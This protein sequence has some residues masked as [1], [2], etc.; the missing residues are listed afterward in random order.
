MKCPNPAYAEHIENNLPGKKPLKN[1][2][3][4]LHSLWGEDV[5]SKLTPPITTPS[6][7][8]ATSSPALKALV[9]KPG[10]AQKMLK[11]EYD[12]ADIRTAADIL[13][14]EDQPSGQLAGLS[15]YRSRG[16]YVVGISR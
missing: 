16:F 3:F 5:S 7:W 11:D 4:T 15:V 2:E 1:M 13:D 10:A 6:G 8:P 9:G 12:V 14:D